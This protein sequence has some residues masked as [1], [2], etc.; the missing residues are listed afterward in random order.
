MSRRSGVLQPARRGDEGSPITAHGMPFDY[1]DPDAIVSLPTGRDPVHN[2]AF[3]EFCGAI[4]NPKRKVRRPLDSTRLC[5][6]L[7][8][9]R[10]G[11][12]DSE[13]APA[14]SHART[15]GILCFN[16][17]LCIYSVVFGGGGI[18]VHACRAML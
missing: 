16:I 10:L 13:R 6:A 2:G 17:F 15:L 5:H 12:I 7:H 8:A 4:T 1:P 11:P 9:Q 3:H 14:R 18:S